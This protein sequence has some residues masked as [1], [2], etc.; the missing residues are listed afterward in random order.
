MFHKRSWESFY[1]GIMACGFVCIVM[2]ILTVVAGQNE[3]KISQGIIVTVV[4]LLIFVV[5]AGLF[6]RYYKDKTKYTKSKID[7]TQ[8][9]IFTVQCGD[10]VEKV[11]DF[12]QIE[13]AIKK[14]AKYR[15]GHV[16]V[17]IA[18][19]MGGLKKFYVCYSNKDP[20]IHTLILQERED[21]LGYWESMADSYLI[22]IDHLKRLYVKHKMVD[23]QG[24]N[25]K[26]TGVD[27]R[28]GLII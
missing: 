25:R 11:Q 14:L 20:Y 28:K 24:L 22:P 4:G 12:S 2:G 5:G 8:N 16:E 9:Y 23:F 26:E 6:A 13:L 18:P 7:K 1:G 19:S 17:D 10:D 3:R 21:G 27:A 15:N